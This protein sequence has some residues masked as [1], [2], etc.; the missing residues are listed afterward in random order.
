MKIYLRTNFQNLVSIDCEKKIRIITMNFKHFLLTGSIQDP[1]P[2]APAFEDL[3]DKRPSTVLEIGSDGIAAMS[4]PQ[5][6]PARLPPLAGG[7]NDG[8]GLGGYRQN[9]DIDQ[10]NMPEVSNFKLI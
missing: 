10:M 2:N 4:S 6:P 1:E 8:D 9:L 5:A 3:Q 7:S